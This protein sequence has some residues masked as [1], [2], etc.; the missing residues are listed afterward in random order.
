LNRVSLAET[1]TNSYLTTAAARQ[2]LPI[3][4][5][6]MGTTCRFVLVSSKDLS[7]SESCF[8]PWINFPASAIKRT[9]FLFNSSILLRK[10]EE[11]SSTFRCNN[12]DSSS[13]CDLAMTCLPLISIG[14]AFDGNYQIAQE[15][16]ARSGARR[17]DV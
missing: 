14:V 8:E 4:D 16:D 6:V 11:S 2:R 5:A 3:V 12:E 17:K 1:S 15:T 10:N 13:C 9:V 7:R